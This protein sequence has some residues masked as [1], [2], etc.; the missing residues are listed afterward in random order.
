[1]RLYFDGWYM[2]K[3]DA[4]RCL[5]KCESL[6]AV[7]VGIVESKHETYGLLYWCGRELFYNHT[8]NGDNAA[9]SPLRDVKGVVGMTAPDYQT[10]RMG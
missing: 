8:I 10:G 9:V 6:G 5:D 2:I 1:M 3:E 4:Q 7:P